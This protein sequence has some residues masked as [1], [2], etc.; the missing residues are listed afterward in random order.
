MSNLQIAQKKMTN[1][2]GV[3][4]NICL[5]L[6]I[7]YWCFAGTLIGAV[8]HSGFIPWDGDIDVGM[9]AEDYEILAKYIQDE[10]PSTMYFFGISPDNGD[11]GISKV[12]DLYSSYTDWSDRNDNKHH[13]LQIDIF[14]YNL[15][16]TSGQKQ[17]K[18]VERWLSS[19]KE[20]CYNFD[21]IFPAKLAKFEDIEI[22]IPKETEKIC[23]YSYGGYPPPFPEKH[24]QVCH[25]GRIDAINPAHY[26]PIVFK[27][28]YKK[29]TQQWFSESTTRSGPLH[30]MS[31]WNYITQEEWDTL[32]HDFIKDMKLDKD[33]KLFD[34][35]CGV[36][37]LFEYINKKYS[38]VQLYGCDI[39]K[40]AVNKCK[41]LFPNSRVSIDDIT[42]LNNYESNYFDN[43]VSIS[44]ISYLNGLDEVTMAVKELL[45]IAKP[46]AKVNFCIMCDNNNGL[47]S[48]NI[49]IPKAFWCKNTF[50]VSEINILDIPFSKFT[51][52]Y[53][54]YIT[55]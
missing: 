29:K 35:G 1:M 27:E 50:Q 55:K 51:N 28:I 45:R 48:F 43:I 34:A 54:V 37:A 47:K 40:P 3:F 18:S 7:K 15:I 32:C 20:D 39:N 12:R 26:Y 9:L 13:G 4:H 8:R 19:Y 23:N 21:D 46:G 30:H 41:L 25:E 10:L 52:R 38:Y 24:R 42:N 31:G 44:T 17:V 6:N 5:K 14:I 33:T 2:L 22:C 49:M 11:R 53:S 36:G 16:E